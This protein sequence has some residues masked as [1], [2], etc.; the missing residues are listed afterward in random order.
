MITTYAL[1][2]IWFFY[3]QF[4][5][6]ISV[7]RLWLK[8]KLNLWNECAYLPL[9]A[10]FFLIDVVLNWTVLLIIGAP[11][12]GCTTMSDRF[13][14]YHTGLNLDGTPYQADQLQKDV[15]TWIC[16]KLLNPIDPSGQH[17]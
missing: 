10:A 5:A 9:L 8:G 15:G 17:C 16:E 7:Y 2:G 3:L 11:P 4:A 13:Q 1:L 14:V 6:A 12:R